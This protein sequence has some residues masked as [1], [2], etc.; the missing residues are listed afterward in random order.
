MHLLWLSGKNGTW[1]SNMSTL[2]IEST[3]SWLYLK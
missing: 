2:L 3:F 1:H